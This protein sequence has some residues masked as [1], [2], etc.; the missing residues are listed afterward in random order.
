MKGMKMWML[1]AILLCSH[2]SVLAQI[3]AEV[4]DVMKKCDAK[5]DN[6]AGLEMDATVKAK[7]LFFTLNGTLKSYMKGKK[8]KD[9]MKMK[10][11]GMEMYEE[12]G[13]DGT[14][15]WTYKKAFGKKEKEKDSLIIKPADKKSKEDT[16]IDLEIYKEYKKA[17]MKVSGKYY[18][19]TLTSPVKKDDPKKMIMKIDKDNYNFR[20]MWAKAGPG[21]MTVTVTRIKIGVSDDVFKFDPKKYPNAVVVRK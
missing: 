7:V 9:I 18:E 14:Y 3:P 8:S 15:D 4:I 10:G 13:F 1:A 21:S 12:S 20:E 5:M 11:M 2:M 19:I 6:P 17:K 16:S